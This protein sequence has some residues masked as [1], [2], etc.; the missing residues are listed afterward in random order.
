LKLLVGLALLALVLVVPAAPASVGDCGS[1]GTPALG[2]MEFGNGSGAWYWDDRDYLLGNGWWFY[3]E[4]NGIYVGG[5][6]HADLQRG[7]S[8]PFEPNDN[9]ICTDDPNVAPDMLIF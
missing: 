2:E 9:E 7:G 6:V 8:S 3:E 1:K 5:D 4:S